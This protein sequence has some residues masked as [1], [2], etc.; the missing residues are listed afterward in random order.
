M[1]TTA[2]IV[3]DD[4]AIITTV[5]D[6]V[7]SLN[8][9]ADTAGD[10]ETAR[11]KL[12]AGD[13]RYLILDMKIPVSPD[14]KLGRREN[15]RN[16]LQTVRSN[17]R[18]SR[19]PVIVVTGEDSGESDFILSVIRAGGMDLTEYIQKPIDGD[20]LD[21][22]IQSLLT[23]SGSPVQQPGAQARQFGKGQRTMVIYKDRIT[24][25][26]VDVWVDRAQDDIRSVL[27]ALAQTSPSGGRVRLRGTH[28]DEQLGRPATNPIRSPIHAFRERCTHLMDEHH[29]LDCGMNDVIAGPKA[30]GYYIPDW[31]TVEIEGDAE[32]IIEPE[33]AT[34]TTCE[35]V[36]AWVLE[37]LAAGSRLRQKDVVEE[38]AGRRERSSIVRD[39][40]TMRQAGVISNGPR[41]TLVAVASCRPAPRKL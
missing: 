26:D 13:Y 11:A 19:L 37:Q 28:L 38:F 21:R 32:T 8:H 24:L 31:I 10:L 6:I 17:P 3:D 1:I 40:T 34:G 14:R 27:I 35:D 16:L 20:K 7:R 12:E 29:G 25:C 36:K 4:P 9:H 30:G 41:S 39:L 22:A 5:G 18:T 15:G 33:A 23:K 2:L